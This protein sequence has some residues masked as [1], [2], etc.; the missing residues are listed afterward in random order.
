MADSGR[1]TAF[2]SR[3]ASFSLQAKQDGIMRTEETQHNS[4]GG[5][6][7]N[8]EFIVQSSAGMISLSE[9]YFSM[10][11][12]YKYDDGS[13]V[14]FPQNSVRPEM[15][16]PEL[17]FQ[18]CDI[19]LNST[20]LSDDNGALYPWKAIARM[21]LTEGEGAGN[22]A[23]HP[24]IAGGNV[25]PGAQRWPALASQDE[26]SGAVTTPANLVHFNTAMEARGYKKFL[27]LADGFTDAEFV[28]P[29]SNSTAMALYVKMISGAGGAG[30]NDGRM[31]FCWQPQEG[32]W[33]QPGFLPASSDL[34]VTLQ[35]G[36]SRLPF[37]TT[38]PAAA[39]PTPDTARASIDYANS[40]IQL[41][42]KRYFLTPS[43]RQQIASRLLQGPMHFPYTRARVARVNLGAGVL[44]VSESALLQGP[45]PGIVAIMWLRSSSITKVANSQHSPW[46]LSGIEHNYG[47]TVT[48]V[49][50]APTSLYVMWGGQQYPQRPYTASDRNRPDP[51]GY[52]AYVDL[53]GDAGSCMSFDQWKQYQIYYF[54]LSRGGTGD[55][56]APGAEDG[57]GSLTVEAT[58]LDSTVSVPHTMIVVG[59]GASHCSVDASGNV[60]RLMY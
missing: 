40:S 47:G 10:D 16:L 42:I 38:S 44:S 6:V 39:V 15:L 43:V 57:T 11:L 1:P 30:I 20:R 13:A 2:D 53:C 4:I 45:R 26:Q 33:H 17:L 32:F 22:T 24:G 28:T 48:S 50:V 51:R 8:P 7:A 25:T 19:Y 54:D 5:I 36:S 52:R 37:R 9:S 60:R 49:G 12:A 18:D 55:E 23:M 31:R 27:V 56:F 41:Y 58:L 34:R 29:T 14:T 3:V 21:L 46:T 35:H 59:F